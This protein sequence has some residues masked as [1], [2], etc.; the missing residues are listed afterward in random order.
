[1]PRLDPV[2][3][4]TFPVSSRSMR[5]PPPRNDLSFHPRLR[6]A[7][8]GAKAGPDPLAG[9]GLTRRLGMADCRPLDYEIQRTHQIHE[10]V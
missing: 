6:S 4:A 8:Q 5:I 2:T 10:I 1:M 9:F 7:W 3:S